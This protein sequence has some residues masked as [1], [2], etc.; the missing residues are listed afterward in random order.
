M[1]KKGSL[2]D[3]IFIVIFIFAIG[4]TI[5][6]SMYIMDK[7]DEKVTFDNAVSEYA[8]SQGKATVL[9]FNELFVF[10]IIGLIIATMVG[11][12]FIE[13]NPVIFWLSF[14]LLLLF[15]F[16]TAILANTFETITEDS[17]LSETTAKFSLITL[18]NQHLGLVML[19]IFALTAIALYAKWRVV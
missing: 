18:F 11:A 3:P 10:I 17:K 1:N 5:I 4:L 13:T 15:L 9:N 16:V 14:L 19:I 12:F 6:F 7:F 2:L 8:I